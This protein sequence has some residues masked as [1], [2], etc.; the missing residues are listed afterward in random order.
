MRSTGPRVTELTRRDLLRGSALLAGGLC[1]GIQPLRSLPADAEARGSEVGDWLRIGADGTVTIAVEKAEMGQGVHTSLAMIV[2]EELEIPWSAVAVEQRV[3]EG[4]SRSMSTGASTSVRNSWEPLA[5]AGAAAREMLIATAAAG[6]NVPAAECRAD[7]GHVRHDATGRAVRYAEIAEAAA[8]LPVPEV[9]PCARAERRLIGRSVPRLDLPA[10]ID[11]TAR[12]GIDVELPGLTR[13][14]VAMPPAAGGRLES[15]NPDAARRAD[16]VIAVHE[17]PDAA[18]GGV[19]VVAEYGWQAR[20]A[21][22]RADVR[23]TPTE[24]F[25]SDAYRRRLDAG[26]DGDGFV[27]REHGEPTRALATAD[28]SH[29]ARYRVPFLAHA[30]LEPPNCT[31]WVRDGGAEFWA[32]TQSAGRLRD[33]AAQL[34]GWPET[35]L[36]VHTTLL[37]G[38]FGRRYEM[39]AALQAAALSRATGRPVQVL[40]SREDDLQHDYY[41][42]AF[43]AELRAGLGADGRP[44]SWE[45]R[46]AGPWF[47]ARDAPA[48]LQRSTFAAQSALGGSVAPRWLPDDVEYRFPRWMR[49]PAS[50]LATLGG[51]PAYDVANARLE[52]ILVDAPVPLGYWRSVGH[53]QNAFFAE[54]FVDE[55]AGIAGADPVAYRR[56]LLAAHPRG[57]AVLDLAAARAGDADLGSGR[58]RGVAVHRSFGTWV[59]QVAEITRDGE[60]MHVDRIVCA[61]DCGDVVHPDTVVAQMEGSIL[62][63]LASLANSVEFEAGAARASNF[64]DYPLPRVE[65]APEI[66][67]H[68][69]PSTEPPGGVGEPGTPPTAPAVANAWAAA[70]GERLRRLPLERAPAGPAK[71]AT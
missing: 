10:K 9:A 24:P 43:A 57:R 60:R 47:E 15:W 6:W 33:R 53:S 64:H 71:R 37:G 35:A 12:F 61:V 68:V 21:L 14:V 23:W 44:T 3:L 41:R 46:V 30:T 2:A 59:A 65:H 13:A 4:P 50:P 55:L 31:A 51:W 1:L 8:R 49:N 26:L 19:G 69:V 16:G 18:G 11:G 42:P 48:W 62:F 20:R 34:L 29:R 56:T 52:W 54:S 32:P 58:G 66:E 17:L 40:W 25:S 27:V 28:R 70:G 5:R 63:G 45:H 22:E 36:R 7:A 67:V 39:R 38:G